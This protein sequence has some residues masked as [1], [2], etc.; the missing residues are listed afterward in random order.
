M[1]EP[2]RHGQ[3]PGRPAEP[4]A[5][6]LDRLVA[7]DPQLFGLLA[8]THPSIGAVTRALGAS[9]AGAPEPSV[10]VVDDVH[11]LT[12]Q[13]CHDIL[14]ALVDHVPVGSQI[15]FASRDRLPL[16]IA[17]LRVKGR[18]VEVGLPDLALDGTEAT[19]LLH[20]ID[21]EL[22]PAE[23]R[24]LVAA[25]EGWPAAVYLAGRSVTARGGGSPIDLADVGRRREIVAYANAELLS[26]LPAGTVRF[27]TRSSVLHQLSGPLCDAALQT[28]E[29]AGQLEELTRSNLLVLPLDERRAWYRYHHL[30]RDLLR[31]E[32]EHREPT[33]VA[34]L[35]RRAAQWCQANGLA[36]AAIEYA[37]AA[38]DAD[39]VAQIVRERVLP[40]YRAGHVVTLNRW[41]DWLDRGGHLPHYPGLA[42][43]AAW[44]AALTA[45]VGAAER[46]ADAAEHPAP[47]GPMRRD[48]DGVRGQKAL[49]RILL[50]R[51]GVDAA[52]ADADTAERRIPPDSPWRAVALGMAGIIRLI[53]GSDTDAD[54]S[55]VQAIECGRDA[56][57]D[58]TTA[59]ALAQRAV[60]ALGRR[61]ESAARDLA[62]RAYEVVDDGP[63]QDSVMNV[64]VFA[65]AARMAMRAGEVAHA[66]TLL[67]QAQRLR[68]KLTY[69]IPHIA[70]QAR[71]ELVRTL[72]Q[73]SDVPGAR[74]VL[75]EI[76]DIV[77]A[78]PRLGVL[79]EQHQTLRA[80]MA[81]APTG[82][83][84][85]SSLTAA[86]LRLLPLL[87]THLTFREIGERL[88][89]SRHTVKTQAIS[90]YRKLGVSS[91]GDAMRVASEIGLLPE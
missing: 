23:V 37:M 77:R 22:T 14:A 18:I 53:A 57:A 11:R 8:V 62:A 6:T 90:I 79:V 9:I 39:R 76:D 46:F 36:D 81:D 64:L 54:A 72:L 31:A 35:N 44:L 4:S 13:T 20:A 80:Q 19:A 67:T 10:L 83:V 26:A 30:F 74:T 33:L 25:T 32:L 91:R 52:L 27:L 85:A 51:D 86:E 1:A 66:R 24:D 71:L 17:T 63:V 60:I 45:R 7:I 68:P 42:V 69:A 21:V 61:D 29:S 58:V 16:P 89:A 2:R 82:A 70:V 34:E 87:Q 73:L 49:L 78:R 43:G 5:A 47:D 88:F 38:G 15:A 28:S 50:C 75:R 40:S 65:V 3:R 56:G 84:T 12:N 59:I 48:S 55:F 41:F